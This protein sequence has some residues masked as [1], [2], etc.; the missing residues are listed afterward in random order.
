[1]WR[2]CPGMRPAGCLPGRRLLWRRRGAAS[3]ARDSP[4]LLLAGASSSASSGS[5]RSATGVAPPSRFHHSCDSMRCAPICTE[6]AAAGSP[7][8]TD[9]PSACRQASQQC[10]SPA[11]HHNIVSITS[12]H[13][14]GR[15]GRQAGGRVDE[16]AGRQQ[17]EGGRAPGCWHPRLPA[18]GCRRRGSRRK[19]PPGVRPAWCAGRTPAACTKSKK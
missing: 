6:R 19:Y 4:H 13:A 11:G 5:R 16:Q 9:M 10:M 8:S 12:T 3:S 2:C 1:M 15:A 7:W 18:G 14:G 17:T